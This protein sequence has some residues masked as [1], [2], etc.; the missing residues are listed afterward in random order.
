MSLLLRYVDPRRWMQ[1]NGL[2]IVAIVALLATVVQMHYVGDATIYRAEIAEKRLTVHRAIVDYDGGHPEFWS[3]TG[4]ETQASR[5]AIPAA[6]DH[7][8]RMTGQP[9][10]LLYTALDGACLFLLL[11][12]VHSL[13]RSWL[14]PTYSLLGLFLFIAVL[15]ISFAFHYFQPW[16]RATQ[17]L[18]A[19]SFLAIRHDRPL[20]LYVLIPLNTFVKF[21]AVLTPAVYFLGHIGAGNWRRVL[22]QSAILGVLA[23][24]PIAF[25]VYLRP[26]AFP[27]RGLSVTVNLWEMAT[28]H[29]A[30]PAVLVYLPLLALA[31]IGRQRADR[32]ALAFVACALLL[33]VPHFL[34]T[35][36][37]EL[38][39]QLYIAILMLPA[40][41]IGLR[42]LLGEAYLSAARGARRSASSNSTPTTVVGTAAKENPR[43]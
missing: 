6:I 23:M 28:L 27:P 3:S 9:V 36:F 10:N 13:L 29:L 37:K 41:L 34:L 24:L 17:L 8:H 42:T 5:F 31:Y 30:H 32:M 33:L 14:D 2:P 40:A 43:T 16:D 18:W 21:D 22:P 39:A 26:D 25:V 38:R 19:L 4:T 7:I 12:A 1:A 11:I 15:P 35:N 20:L